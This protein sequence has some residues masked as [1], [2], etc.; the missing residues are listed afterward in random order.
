MQLID[1]LR[2]RWRL[3]KKAKGL[4]D[5]I[6]RRGGESVRLEMRK[7]RQSKI[8]NHKAIIIQGLIR[9]WDIGEIKKPTREE[10]NT[11]MWFYR[12]LTLSYLQELEKKY[13]S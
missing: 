9:S 5:E 12:G 11:L 7:E 2:R 13:W 6:A 3:F 1:G 10:Y 4:K 8:R